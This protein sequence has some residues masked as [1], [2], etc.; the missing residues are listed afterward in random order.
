MK[1]A[2]R[3]CLLEDYPPII[4][5][6]SAGSTCKGSTREGSACKGSAPTHHF[7]DLPRGVLVRGI[8]WS[9][10]G[11]YAQRE[12]SPEEYPTLAPPK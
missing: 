9:Y 1:Y 6:A 7:V 3:E 4:F 12:C 8:L 11:E 2:Q 5:G 10:C